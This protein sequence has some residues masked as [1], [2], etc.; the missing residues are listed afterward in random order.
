VGGRTWVDVGA[1]R[2]QS[3]RVTSTSPIGKVVQP[4]RLRMRVGGDRLRDV[5]AVF[6]EHLEAAGDGAVYLVVQGSPARGADAAAFG[7]G[8]WLLRFPVD[9]SPLAWERLPAPAVPDDDQIRHLA[10]D[11]SG[12]VF[13]LSALRSGVLLEE[14]CAEGSRC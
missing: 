8:R 2:A 11:G 13:L 1:Y 4:V 7:G 12:D 9:G 6:S 14:R 5:P 3:F 10:I